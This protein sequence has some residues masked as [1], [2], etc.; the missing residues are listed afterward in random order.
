MLQTSFISLSAA[1]FGILQ[2]FVLNQHLIRHEQFS[3]LG[4]NG[5]ENNV[6]F[7]PKRRK[8]CSGS[9]AEAEIKNQKFETKNQKS[10]NL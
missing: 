2:L 8:E 10:N 4:E 1:S 6:D 3:V 9:S 5:F 7:S